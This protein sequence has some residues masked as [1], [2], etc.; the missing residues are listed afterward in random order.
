MDFALNDDQAAIQAAARTFAAAELAPHS[1][2]WD[3]EKVFPVQTLRAAAA[4]GFAGLYV[5]EEVGGS[6]LSR[7]DAALVFEELSRG[8]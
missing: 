3:E 7:L 4:L 6:G 1:A 8:D 2:R 5:R